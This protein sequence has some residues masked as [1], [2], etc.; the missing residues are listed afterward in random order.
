MSSLNNPVTTN[1]FG[2]KLPSVIIDR[3]EISPLSGRDADSAT[4]DIYLSV[5]FTKPEHMQSGTIEL[6]IK[7]ADAFK[8][9]FLYSYLTYSDYFYDAARF[10]FGATADFLHEDLK[11]NQ[12]SLG[13]WFNTEKDKFNEFH[14]AACFKKISLSQILGLG[15]SELHGGTLTTNSNFDANGNEII[16]ISGIQMN[17]LYEGSVLPDAASGILLPGY[18]F[19]P[20]ISTA[21]LLYFA[22]IGLDNEDVF[23]TDRDIVERGNT[24]QNIYFG[25]ITYYH[26]LEN[27]VVPSKFYQAYTDPSGVPYDGPVLQSINGNVYS[28][29]QYSF[30]DIKESIM[31]MISNFESSRGSDSTLDNNI[32]SLEAIINA[33]ENTI[34]VLGELATYRS[35][36][37]NKSQATLSGEFYN[38]FIIAFQQII[39][40]VEAQVQL[41]STLLYDSL[42]IDNRFSLLGDGYADPESAGTARPEDIVPGV[43]YT[44]PSDCFIPKKWFMLTRKSFLNPNIDAAS[45]PTAQAVYGISNTDVASAAGLSA[46]YGEGALST[47]TYN[48]YFEES[49]FGGSM[50]E[51]VSAYMSE[52]MSESIAEEMAAD[53]ID[54]TFTTG[55]V[56]DMV[57]LLYPSSDGSLVDALE[58]EGNL[59]VKHMGT[60]MFDYEKAL[61]TQS[62]ISKIFDLAKLQLLMRFNIS[63][64]TFFMTSTELSRNELRIGHTGLSGDNKYI[65]TK[66]QLKFRTPLN[67]HADVGQALPIGYS[68]DIRYTGASPSDEDALIFYYERLKNLH[69]VVGSYSHENSSYL[70]PFNFDLPNTDPYDRLIKYNSMDNA[71]VN[72]FSSL[73]GQRVIDGYRLI[74]YKFQEYMDDDVAYYNTIYDSETRFVDL[75]ASNSLDEPRT[76]YGITVQLLDRTCRSYEILM[77]RFIP[78]YNNFLSYYRLSADLCSYNNIKSTFNQW[79]TD[80]IND[81]QPD[82]PWIAAAHA[83][84]ILSELIFKSGSA[85]SQIHFETAILETIFKIAPE[86][87]NLPQLEKFMIEYNA[88]MRY[89]CGDAVEDLGSGPAAGVTTPYTKYLSMQPGVAVAHQFY[90]EKPIWEPVAGLLNPDLSSIDPESLPEPAV[91]FTLL[92]A[93]GSGDDHPTAEFLTQTNEDVA[94]KAPGRPADRET[95]FGAT[96][97]TR[98]NSIYNVSDPPSVLKYAHEIIWWPTELNKLHYN[99][100]NGVKGRA[101]DS[102]FPPSNDTGTWNTNLPTYLNSGPPRFQTD[103]TTSAFTMFQYW[104]ERIVRRTTIDNVLNTRGSGARSR[105]AA[106]GISSRRNKRNL[107]N[108]ATALRALDEEAFRRVHFA[109]SSGLDF[110]GAMN[111]RNV[112]ALETVRADLGYDPIKMLDVHTAAEIGSA[113][114]P[115]LTG[116]QAVRVLNIRIRNLIAAI[117][118]HCA[119]LVNDIT[120]NGTRTNAEAQEYFDQKIADQIASMNS[121]RAINWPTGRIYE[122]EAFSNPYSQAAILGTAYRFIFTFRGTGEYPLVQIRRSDGTYSPARI[123]DSD[124]LRSSTAY[125]NLSQSAKN[126]LHYRVGSDTGR[127]SSL[128]AT[129]DIWN[130]VYPPGNRMKALQSIKYNDI[131]IAWTESLNSSNIL[132]PHGAAQY[133][134]SLIG[135]PYM[136]SDDLVAEARESLRDYLE[137]A[138]GVTPGSS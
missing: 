72:G 16:T 80:E 117:K 106:T 128:K 1:T 28:A 84:Q 9:M 76:C 7:Q 120:A 22:F 87:G 37:P 40:S 115:F 39:S 133:V 78:I 119:G 18:A 137:A 29:E 73:S 17:C 57:S 52:G 60:F 81:L 74:T 51:L 93:I 82:K 109:F 98:F 107:F 54:Y 71:A 41:S 36:Y 97:A 89:L 112:D 138:L 63:Y 12:F 79:F 45:R 43:P 127:D 59:M 27:N 21:D 66:L 23:G 32:K 62:K 6:I 33:S 88:L 103:T 53:F 86:T 85:V 65:R 46:G 48:D 69:P 2:K 64:G 131:N 132:G 92:Q 113:A 121:H 114:D 26:V 70:L 135:G 13:N 47:T 44:A 129:I 99:F 101:E 61:R 75:R 77:N 55:E 24:N 38:Q 130:Q 122:D 10:P 94:F 19:R 3:I 105:I 118:D 4:I 11:N 136:L 126:A 67:A 102:T 35:T 108:V 104:I 100:F 58:G 56:G 31:D 30:N 90:N 8:N 96:D 68:N 111:E 42:V 25:D 34:G 91:I 20:P 134:Y 83:A 125:R 124:E 50:E 14:R 15:D 95:V 116:D 49:E 123:L 110:T 5:S